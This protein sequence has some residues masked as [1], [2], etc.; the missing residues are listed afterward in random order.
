MSKETGYAL[1]FVVPALLYWPSMRRLPELSRARAGA[2]LAS[3]FTLGGFCAAIRYAVFHGVGGF[4]YGTATSAADHV[5][6]KSAYQ[7][8][9]N[10]A[11][12]T[13]FAIKAPEPSPIVFLV[14]GVYVGVILLLVWS[15]DQSRQDGVAFRMGW[16]ALLSALPAVA[17]IG[18]IKPT[19]EHTRHLYLPSVWIA[20]L[21]GTILTR[22]SVKPMLTWLLLAVQS[23]ALLWNMQV[24]RDVLE[25]AG[26]IAA[27]AHDNIRTT[28]PA[29]EIRLT[30]VPAELDGVWYFDAELQHQLQAR[31]AVPV[32]LCDAESPCGPLRKGS[33]LLKWESS[34][35]RLEISWQ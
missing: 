8:L 6:L 16:L 29:A 3:L 26:T 22:P 7:L 15:S 9:A 32:H 35:S 34:E 13:P 11:G 30:G 18:W 4:G 2:Y 23:A 12:L 24:Y 27:A 1:L 10:V 5:S 31:S 17:V 19:L 28:E 20:L 21:M 33:V 14:V 25:R